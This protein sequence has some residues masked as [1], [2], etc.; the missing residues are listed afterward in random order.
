MNPLLEHSAF[1]TRRQF[2]GRGAMGFSSAALTSSLYHNVGC[3]LK[4]REN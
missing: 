3:A 4:H 1:L 2:L